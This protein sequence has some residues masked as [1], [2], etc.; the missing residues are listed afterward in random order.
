MQTLLARYG[1]TDKALVIGY[2]PM[3][4]ESFLGEALHLFGLAHP[5]V[6]VQIHEMSPAEQVKSLRAEA[7][8]VAFIGNSPSELD[9]EFSVQCVERVP[10]SAILPINHRF[11]DLDSIHL[12]KLADEKFIG[13]S[14]ETFPR[15]NDYICDLCRCNGFEVNLHRSAS[16][17]ASMIALIA[18]GQG[19]A[20]IP[21]EAKALPICKWCLS[22]SIH[23]S[24]RDR[25]QCGG[26]NPRLNH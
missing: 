4:L 14:E 16:S 12:S 23:R 7:I 6:A 15:R 25:P 17:S 13:V 11:A 3:I 1:T 21:S 24:M 9:A 8:D 10:C 2:I 18:V 20:L 26:R 19:V 5:Q 22:R